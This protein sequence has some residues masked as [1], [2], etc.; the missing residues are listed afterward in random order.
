M[1]K[2]C[3]YEAPSITLDSFNASSAILAGSEA[4]LQNSEMN[5]NNLG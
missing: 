3:L 5:F 1:N 2:T 4:R